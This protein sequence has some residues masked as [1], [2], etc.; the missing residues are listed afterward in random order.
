MPETEPLA[1]TL[2]IRRLVE[3]LLRSGSI[4][5]RFTGFDRANEG[6]RLHRKLQRA[7]VKEYPDYEAEATLRQEF[8]CEGITYTLEG[9]A[10]GLFTDRDGMRTID[11][12][13]TTTLP[14]EF[15]TGEQSPEHWAQAQCYAAIY[16]LQND[17]PAM[18]VRLTYYQVDEELEFNFTHDYTAEALQDIVQGLLTQYAPLG[19][20]GSSLATGQTRQFAGADI[21]LCGLPARPA[22]DDRGRIQDLLRGRAAAVPGPHRHWQDNERAVPCP[23]SAGRRRAGVLPDGP[24]H[25][26]RCRRKRCGCAAWPRCQLKAA[27][28]DADRER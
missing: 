5:S 12:I 26:P 22:G 23:E 25:H 14:P 4:D 18:R 2:P 16:A 24:R 28:R 10:D 13:K 15:I 9:R 21:S 17:L 19:A 11:E 8:G 1:L 27:Q 20:A 7:A 3:F 6:A